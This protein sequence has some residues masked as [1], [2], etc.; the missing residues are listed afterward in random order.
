MSAPGKS[1]PPNWAHI[2]NTEEFQHLLTKK[3]RFIFPALSFFFLYYFLLPILIGFAPHLMSTQIIGTFTLAY[4]FAISQ[5]FVG[6]LIA[7][8]YLR[9]SAKFDRL[10]KEILARAKTEQGAN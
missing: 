5:F 4:A 9:A 7:A 8:L 3:R 6:W 2:A 10:A 1:T